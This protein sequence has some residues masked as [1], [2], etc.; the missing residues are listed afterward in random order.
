MNVKKKYLPCLDLC[1]AQ[2]HRKGCRIMLTC[3]LRRENLKAYCMQLAILSNHQ[4]GRDTH[5][6]QIKVFGPRH[7]VLQPLGQEIGFTTVELSQ[8][9]T[10]R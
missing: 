10:V 7:D 4:N 8:F 2:L 3:V 6:R 9:A 5:V 1:I